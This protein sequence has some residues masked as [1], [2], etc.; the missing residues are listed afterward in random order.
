MCMCAGPIESEIWDK[1]I[2]GG[3][4]AEVAQQKKSGSIYD[5]LVETALAM[6]RRETAKPGFFFPAS[7]VGEKVYAVRYPYPPLLYHLW[8]QQLRWIGTKSGGRLGRE[9]RTFFDVWVGPLQVLNSRSPAVRYVITPNWFINWLA[10]TLFPSR[11]ADKE[12]TRRYRL[13][14]CALAC[15][16]AWAPKEALRLRGA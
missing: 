15:T 10:P 5:A 12:I 8:P 14:K 16:C 13:H 4:L 11:L 2:V 7:R 9:H 3:E 6:I 1:A